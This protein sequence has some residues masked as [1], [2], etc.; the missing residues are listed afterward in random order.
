[1]K[2]NLP[3]TVFSLSAEETYQIGK[4]F[5]S[6]MKG[7]ELIILTG[8]LGMGKTVLAKGIASGMGIDPDD[9]NSP[10]FLI[11][12]EH[13]GRI[14]L[15]HIDLYRIKSEEEIEEIG[16]RDI[17][18]IGGVVVVEWGEKLPSFYR[19]GAITISISDMGEDT[20]KI[21]IN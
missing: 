7:G 16:I 1:M 13:R 11:V 5:G 2:N 20:R 12:N 3:C 19:K 21:I 14:K 18:E 9:V 6:R 17:L 8:E 15:F 10:S 4:S